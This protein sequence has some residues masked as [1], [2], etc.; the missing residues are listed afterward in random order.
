MI[1]CLSCSLVK[2]DL[3]VVYFHNHV[4]QS[5]LNLICE[6]FVVPYVCV[7]VCI[8]VSVC[9]GLPMLLSAASRH[10]LQLKWKVFLC[11]KAVSLFPW[12]HYYVKIPEK[13]EGGEKKINVPHHQQQS[14]PSRLPPSKYTRQ[15]MHTQAVGDR[16]KKVAPATK[17]CL[18]DFFTEGSGQ[19]YIVDIFGN[20]GRMLE[21]V[22]TQR[23]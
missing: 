22:M 13:T 12:C 17:I 5:Y 11:H 20:S 8:S 18:F 14:Q 9:V 7:C 10:S 16:K 15:H 1:A 3:W 6:C 21:K 2:Q 19:Q 4:Q 23:G